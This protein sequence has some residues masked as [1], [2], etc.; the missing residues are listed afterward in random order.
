MPV[1]WRPES[2][3]Q[4]RFIELLGIG[5]GC[6]V[7]QLFL[8]LLGGQGHGPMNFPR[9]K[10]KKSFSLPIPKCTQVW[11]GKGEAQM[12]RLA[13]KFLHSKRDPQNQ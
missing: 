10:K 5:S 13:L 2:L 11:E 12:I 9:W 4:S 6:G 1:L 8:V 3:T 7:K